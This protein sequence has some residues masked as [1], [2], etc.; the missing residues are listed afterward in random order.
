MPNYYDQILSMLLGSGEYGGNQQA[1][2]RADAS[3]AEDDRFKSLTKRKRK[4]GKN[5]RM[6]EG[7]YALANYPGLSSAVDWAKTDEINRQY[8]KVQQ[9]QRNYVNWMNAANSAG[10]N[11]TP[12]P[13]Q[14]DWVKNYQN[15]AAHEKL[16]V[17]QAQQDMARM[18]QALQRLQQELSQLQTGA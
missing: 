18:Q 9:H 11:P 14:I 8:K 3:V 12:K 7:A 1:L 16:L 10:S 13:G 15:M 6:P 17:A 4:L 2:A 5:E